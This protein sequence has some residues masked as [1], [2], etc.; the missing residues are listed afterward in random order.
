MLSLGTSMTVT[1]NTE[2]SDQI[3]RL[4]LRLAEMMAGTATYCDDARAHC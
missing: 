3:D 4:N 2:T 1:R